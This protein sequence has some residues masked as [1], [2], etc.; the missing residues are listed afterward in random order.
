MTETVDVCVVGAG[1]AGLAA[2]ARAAE[3]GLRVVLLDEQARPGGQYFRQVSPAV[4]AT[5]GVHR[6]AGHALIARAIA[7]G[8]QVRTGTTV[9][10][11]RMRASTCSAHDML[12]SLPGQPSGRFPSRAGLPR[13]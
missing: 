7:A 12:S 8:V 1:P 9:W 13:A 4:A 5:A 10:G 2:A 6:P 11:V 3:H